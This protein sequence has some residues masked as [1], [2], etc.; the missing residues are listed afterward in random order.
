M[1]FGVCGPIEQAPMVAD[2]GFDFLEV[3]VQAVLQP[4]TPSKQWRPPD[5]DALPLPIETANCLVPGDLPIIGPQRDTSALQD[6]MQRAAKRA[7]QLGISRLVF[8]SG[9]ARQRPDGVDEQTAWQHL[10]AFTRMAGEV[11][12]HHGVRLVIEH[13]NDKETN[14]VISLAEAEQLRQAVNH[15]NVTLLIDN[16][17]LGMGGE[18][19]DAVVPVVGQVDHVHVA[20]VA[21]RGY[22][23]R[24]GEP[25]APGPAFD[26]AAFFDALK[27]GGYDQRI[28][29][30]C[31]WP[32]DES[33]K[34]DAMARSCA[35]LRK[36]WG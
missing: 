5:T 29:I 3:N 32:E 36:L 20:E 10:R 1:R 28:S 27:S 7:E 30:E 6:Y 2:A 24:N 33:A 12:Q 25:D 17:H 35:L 22:P 11:C 16:Y 19:I 23:G 15:D 34:S 13:L 4:T 8:G 14:T 26:F 18:G 31:R 9:G 21:G